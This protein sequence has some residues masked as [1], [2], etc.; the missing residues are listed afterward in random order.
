MFSCTTKQNEYV[1][2]QNDPAVCFF[3]I[4]EGEVDVEVDDK[5]VKT[6]TRG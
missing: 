6:L 4:E 2:M 3:I 5:Y 1:F